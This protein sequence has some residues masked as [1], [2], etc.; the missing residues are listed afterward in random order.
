MGDGTPQ[1]P[2]SA[3]NITVTKQHLFISYRTDD[4]WAAAKLIHQRLVPWFGAD[5]VFLDVERIEAGDTWRDV[6]TA[7]LDQADI[8]IVVIGLQW[9]NTVNKTGQRRLDQDNDV[10]RWEVA[11]A[12]AKGKR[13]IPVLIDGASLPRAEELPVPLKALAGLNK[14]DIRNRS[15]DDDTDTLVQ[16]LGGRG[17]LVDELLRLLK[18]LKSSVWL[19]PSIVLAIAMFLWV[20]LFDIAGLDTRMASATLALGDV[21]TNNE[22]SDAVRLVAFQPD[23]KQPLELSARQD[24][25]RLIQVLSRAGAARISFDLHFAKDSPSFDARL[26]EAVIEARNLKTQVIFGFSVLSNDLPKTLEVLRPIATLGFLCIQERLGE[27]TGSL[28][29]FRHGKHLYPGLALLAAKGPLQIEDL[30]ALEFKARD[31]KG[32]AIRSGYSVLEAYQR[33]PA[34]PAV[35][36][37]DGA[38][39]LNFPITSI[40]KLRAPLRRFT[41]QQVL[42]SGPQQLRPAFAGKTVLVGFETDDEKK[43][44]R[45]DWFGATRYGYEFHAD[46][47]SALLK[48]DLVS[49]P[50]VWAQWAVM[51]ALAGVGL[52]LRLAR[53]RSPRIRWLCLFLA[54]AACMALSLGLYL[55]WRIQMNVLY[56]WAALLAAYWAFGL[57]EKRINRE[58]KP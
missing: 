31:G 48:G 15:F 47:T 36:D 34:C 35:A 1:T 45:L 5:H 19:L 18:L 7:Q 52:G 49:V 32:E 21:I 57:V 38:A 42:G 22:P 44:T 11:H 17:R 29:V 2:F 23:P 30:N 54:A 53:F 43:T 25:A 27:A 33:Q 13:V 51:M 58:A 46:A 40:A 12:L 50:G 39:V 28:L 24:Y 56:Q 55:N 37:G 14:R 41:A 20:S 16:D 4:S 8:V 6:L 3:Q 26:V 10:V 9:L